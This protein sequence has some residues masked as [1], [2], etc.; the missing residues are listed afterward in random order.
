MNHLNI[1]IVAHV[2]AGKTSLTER[3]LFDAGVIT[4]I[5]SV[6]EG[7]TQTDSLALERKR[8]ITIQSAVVAFRIGDLRVNV[9]DTPGHSDFVA[10]VERALRVL[11]G[12]VLVVSAVE[13]VQART[14]VLIRSLARLRIPVLV[15]VNKIDRRGA[16]YADLLDEIAAELGPNCVAMGSVADAGT[17]DARFTAFAGTDARFAARLAEAFADHDDAFV[18]AYLDDRVTLTEADFRRALA[19]HVEHAR[20]YPVFFGSAITGEGID[21]LVRGIAE[22]LPRVGEEAAEQPLRAVVLKIERGRA[23]EKIAYVRTRTGTLRPRAAVAFFRRDHGGGVIESSGRTSAVQVFDEGTRLRDADATAGTIA[24]VRGLAE[25]RVGDHLGAADGLPTRGLFAP[26]TLESEVTPSR[27][28]QRPALYAALLRI[29]EQDPMID[30]RGDEA[31]GAISVRLYGEVQKEV[32]AATLADTY[33][34]RVVFEESRPLYFE[35]PV[36]VGEAVQE[37]TGDGV[38]FFW[39]TVGLR[40]EPADPGAGIVFRLG[41]QLGGLPLAFHRAIEE[42]VHGTLRQGVRGWEVLDCAVTLTRTGFAGPLSA[43]GDFRNVTPLVVGEALE[44]AGT[45]V[46]EPTHR[47]ELEAPATCVGAVSALLAGARAVPE[48]QSTRGDRCLVRGTIPAAELHGVT[49][50]LPESTRGE[51]VLVSEFEGYRAFTGHPIPIRARTGPDPYDRDRYML[52]TL[53]RVRG[54]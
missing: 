42:S 50:R 46:F 37:I 20:V 5:G 36:G 49:R 47:F 28:A 14:R 34:L 3:L 16:R 40:V 32:I 22:L 52:H 7:S 26:P 18:D 21:H 54:S 33:D 39:A 19:R 30:V 8:G 2:D 1:G 25:V 29:A 43:A 27:P 48:E 11:D 9:I 38:N 31:T 4:R 24:K 6:D 23:G 53:G 13:G 15:F 45:R 12:A 51:G 35:K 10:E 41:V 17:P 44:R